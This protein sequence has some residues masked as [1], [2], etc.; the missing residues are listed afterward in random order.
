MMI[1]LAIGCVVGLF[2]VA[3]LILTLRDRLLAPKPLSPEER[4][5]RAEAWRAR[6]LSPDWGAVERYLA[7][8]VPTAVRELYADHALITREGLTLV[9]PSGSED[10][11]IACFRPADAQ[12][13]AEGDVGIPPGAFPFASNV[14]GDPYYVLAPRGADD[15]PVYVLYHDGGDVAFVAGSLREL[16]T[17]PRRADT[18]AGDSAA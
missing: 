11:D 18:A 9:G 16:L 15:G 17:W 3:A 4:R 13:L 10:W 5:A 8:P 2:V 14:F 12:A 6:L 1:L 7:R